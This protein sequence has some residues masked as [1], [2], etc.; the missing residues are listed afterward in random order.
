MLQDHQLA[1]AE[2]GNAMRLAGAQV[3]V[4]HRTQGHLGKVGIAGHH[5]MHRLAQ[6]AEV[7]GFRHVA[8][9]TGLHAAQ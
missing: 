4:M 5:R 3:L 9:G 1:V 7:V 8:H 2:T 6:L